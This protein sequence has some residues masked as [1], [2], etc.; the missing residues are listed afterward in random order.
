M[1]NGREPRPALCGAGAT[2][3]AAPSPGGGRVSSAAGLVVSLAFQGLNKPLPCK[4]R[5][6]AGR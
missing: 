4:E 3:P 1:P 6:F 2:V 5:F